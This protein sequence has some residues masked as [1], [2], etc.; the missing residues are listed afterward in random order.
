MTLSDLA[1]IME[2]AI[3]R[4][5]AGRLSGALKAYAEHR[6]LALVAERNEDAYSA[7]L[8]RADARACLHMYPELLAIVEPET[9]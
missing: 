9:T 4:D 6:H 5:L 7:H 8:H 3:Q 1:R 2:D